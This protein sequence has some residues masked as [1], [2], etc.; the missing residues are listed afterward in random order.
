MKVIPIMSTKGGVGKSK[1]CSTLARALKDRG[2]KV[3]LLD[4]DWIAP[5]LHIELGIE[6]EHG[7]VLSEGVGDNIQP[8][9]TP[10]GFLLVSSAF[11]FPP[12]QAISMDEESTIKDI[13]EIIKPGVINWDVNGPLDFLLMDT[14]PTT[15][16]F[17]KTALKIP[18]L[19]GVVL[20]TQPASTSIADLLR[21]TS[22]LRDIHVPVLGLI[23]NQVFMVCPHG[24]K[25]NLYDLSEK[26]IEAFCK[27]QGVTYLGSVPHVIPSQGLPTLDGVVD[28]LL[29]QVPSYLTTIP[30]SVLPYKILLALARRKK[31]G[32]N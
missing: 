6:R 23:G 26:D 9:I 28:N 25:V 14:P 5:N 32:E 15:A 18:D 8:V 7:L 13:E 4:V 29:A 22:L 31:G 21:T 20:V 3:G 11:I 19:H 24:E 27:S 2:F 16:Q 10:E 1:V 30:V 12:D 17:V